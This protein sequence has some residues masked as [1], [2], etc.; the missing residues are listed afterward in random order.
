M[1]IWRKKSICNYPKDFQATE[2]VCKL[3]KS[4]YGL[5]QASRQWFAKLVQELVNQ[6]FQQFKNDYSLNT[7]KKANNITILAIYVDDII[8]TGNNDQEIKN[9]KTH[10]NNVFRIKD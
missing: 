9:M 8:L 10:L 4:L 3:K 6:G 7:K 1:E 5:K 2:A